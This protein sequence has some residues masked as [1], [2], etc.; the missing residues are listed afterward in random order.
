LTLDFVAKR[1][2]VLPSYAMKFGD[3]IDVRCA[4]ISVMYETYL[5][6]K[7]TEGFKDKSDH[8]YSQD[9][10]LE[11]VERAKQRGGKDNKK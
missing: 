4:N 5:N 8:G 3:S 2:G 1:Y 7:N 9:Q 10:L 6:K 11:M